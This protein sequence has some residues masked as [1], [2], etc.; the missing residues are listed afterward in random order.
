MIFVAVWLFVGSFAKAIE[1]N[2]IYNVIG[3]I[4]NICL[5]SGT[6]EVDEAIQK[7]WV[8]KDLNIKLFYSANHWIFWDIQN[9]V[10]RSRTG[11]LA[12]LETNEL[13]DAELMNVKQTMDVSLA[14]L[15]FQN[16]RLLPDK[17]DWKLLPDKEVAKQFSNIQVYDLLWSN[18]TANGSLVYYK[19]R[20]YIDKGNLLPKRIE[21]W[22]K[23]SPSG[24]YELKNWMD[25]TYPQTYEV[26][27]LIRENGFVPQ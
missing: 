22:Q 11:E 8:S 6:S 25:I 27:K 20:V 24:K 14:L 12:Y 19:W 17:Y 7:V 18:K 21:N 13:N 23:Y 3:K 9:K 2:D 16:P 10:R 1:F 4:K 26:E 5:I 15:P